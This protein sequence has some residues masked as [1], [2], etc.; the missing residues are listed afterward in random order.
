MESMT[1]ITLKAV[2][3]LLIEDNPADARLV[4][5][6]FKDFKIDNKLYVVDDGVKAI[7]FLN[8]EGEYNDVPVPDLIM[9]DLNLPRKDGREVLAEIKQDEN[10]KFIPVVILTTSSDKTDIIN[11][12][13][14]HANCFITKPVD[15]EQFMIVLNS[16]EDF[17]LTIVKLPQKD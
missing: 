11:T 14:N 7:D 6:V 9:L 16:I 12:Y 10:L 3:V 13:K 1:D 4:K 8:H 15:F 2:K 5:E 17:W